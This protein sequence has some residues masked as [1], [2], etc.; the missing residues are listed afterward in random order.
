M[1]G[2][3][4]ERMASYSSRVG[5]IMARRL[6]KVQDAYNGQTQTYINF[7]TFFDDLDSCGHRWG[8]DFCN[9][10]KCEELREQIKPLIAQA[11]QG[12]TNG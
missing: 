6:E 3:K 9:C 8:E 7:D 4:S 5:A 1:A 10:P 11:V 2:E 12:Q